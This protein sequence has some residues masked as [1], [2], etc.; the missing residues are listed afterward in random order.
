MS[1]LKDF[2]K[3][4]NH[5][6]GLFFLF[7]LSF[8][9]IFILSEFP[10]DK[11]LLG[12]EILGFFFIIYLSIQ[13]SKFRK[14]E[15]FKEK[16]ENLLDENKRL[17]SAYIKEK[18]DLEEYFLL[19]TH[20]IKTPIT[21]ANLIL[22]KK[23]D[24]DTKKLKEEMF[25]IEEYT[26]MAINYI[27]LTDRATDMDIEKVDLDRLIKTLLKKYSLIFINKK[28]SLDYRD[29]EVEVLTDSKLLSIMIEQIISN[30]LKYTEDG[31]IRIFFDK[32]KSTLSIMDT[33][34]GI[35]DE[36]L[37]KIFDRGYSG[38]NGRVNHKSS[39]LGLFLVR[40]I[41]K[42]LKLRVEVK[43]KLGQGSEFFIIFPAN[44]TKL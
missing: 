11:F 23:S 3:S 44:L 14:E 29:T 7:A 28:I 41:S 42:I 12:F 1:K 34:I 18:K 21:V 22:N 20:Q 17:R 27:K 16:Y 30:A 13:Y 35:R 19:W 39:G 32:E 26:N 9:A 5:I 2:L 24:P 38:F 6:I 25:Y 8:F 15:S 4:Q 31:K 37:V 10:L 43:S 36:D 33:G 40:E